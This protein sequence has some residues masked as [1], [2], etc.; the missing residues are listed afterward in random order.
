MALTIKEIVKNN[1]AEFSFLRAGNAYYTVTV[2]DVV[3][4]FPVPLED[5]GGGSLFVEEKAITLMRYIRKA[6]AEG[7]F[8][9]ANEKPRKRFKVSWVGQ[10]A[11]Y[12]V[13]IPNYDGGEV[14]E[15]RPRRK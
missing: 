14:V 11:E 12:K 1:I 5:I 8:V 4:L 3:Y 13:S 2:N 6:L 7:T 15:A 10:Y 9:K